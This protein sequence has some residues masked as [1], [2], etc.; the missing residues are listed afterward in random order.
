VR[1]PA[2]EE[3]LRAHEVGGPNNGGVWEF[4][5]DSLLPDPLCGEVL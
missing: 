4:F 3:V 5:P 1:E 2:D